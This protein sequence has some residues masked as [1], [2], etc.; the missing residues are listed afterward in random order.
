MKVDELRSILSKYDQETTRKL[1]VEM[2][3]LIPK[4]MREDVA[5]DEFIT[6]FS[7][8]AGSLRK[9]KSKKGLITDFD[10][11]RGR[12][13]LFVEYA[14]TS[15][16]F[17]PNRIVPKSER[18]KW[19]VMA[20]KLLKSLIATKGENTDEAALLLVEMYRMLSYACSCLLMRRRV[21]A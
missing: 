4:R 17:A 1:V 5:L 13:E 11:L 18:S 2:Y 6:T 8:E 16:Y 7:D 12:T 19:R 10:E 21:G 20:R 9:A 14:A 3:K 15:Y